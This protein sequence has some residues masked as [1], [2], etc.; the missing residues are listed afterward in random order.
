MYNKGL[1][2]YHGSLPQG[3]KESFMKYRMLKRGVL[4]AMVAACLC[5]AGCYV[6]P[7]EI[8]D[9]TQ[10]MTIGSNNLPFQTLPPQ[11]TVTPT[12]TPTARPQQGQ[13]NQQGQ[14][15]GNTIIQPQNT[16]NI[17]WDENWGSTATA[18]PGNVPNYN[19]QGGAITVVTQKPT[20]TPKPATPTPTSNSLK[21]GS[22]GAAVRELQQ[23]LKDLG[24]YT[25][26]VDGDF[27]TGTENA[28]RAF[29]KANG[30]TQDGKAGKNTLAKLY[31]NN[32]VPYSASQQGQQN[33]QNQQQNQNRVTP[34][35]RPT[36]TPNL[37]NARYLTVGYSGND[38][39]RLQQRLIDLGYLG[40][41]ANGDFGAA[42]KAAVVA[43]QGRM[44]LWDDGIAGP[45][46]QAKL[47]SNSA[48]KASS[49][50][51]Y[52]GESLKQ[53]MNGDGVRA[54][55]KQL[56]KLGYY[57]GTVDGDYGSG[58]VT[59]VMAFQQNNGLK[60]DG[61]AGNATLNK[62][63]A[64]D[65][66]KA[67]GTIGNNNSNGNVIHSSSGTNASGVGSSQIGQSGNNNGGMSGTGGIT[68]Q[69]SSTG[70]YTL[71]EGDKS[72]GVRKLQQALKN[73]GYYSG[74]VDG[75]YGSGTTSAVMAFQRMNNLTVDG[76]AGPATQRALYGTNTDLT[77]STLREGDEGP[78][79]L[80]L[81]YTLY[82]LGYYDGEMNS[83]YGATTR[84][85]VRAFQIA[86]HLTPVDGVAGNKT[87]Q[88]LYS[89]NA[90]PAQAEN[91]TYTTLRKGD[92]GDDVVQ[93]QDVLCQLGYLKEVTGEYDNATVAAVRTFQQ[94]NGL[95]V[96]GVAGATTQQKLYSNPVP[97]P[98]W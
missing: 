68:G 28:V 25:G 66:V 19:G 98:S 97:F 58:T 70:Y 75:T 30:L 6:P 63:Y 55:Q 83:V 64:D 46:T 59:A 90:V 96:D 62:L 18:T 67:N 49:M 81:Q 50:A 80:N 95:A 48:K 88:K 45:D 77:Y 32:A 69:V 85:A 61:I 65:V 94:Y 23:R 21:N 86:N 16:P 41:K 60:A 36:A 35:P 82:E 10:N 56:K 54:L 57:N 92:R 76:K 93:L 22:T 42:T 73:L 51:A 43:F 38:V 29:Q 27:G 84:D 33:Q 72:D 15:G 47:Y 12:P 89:S 26:T 20:N 91:N 5:L 7:D 17:N 74:K 8:S 9:N 31:S 3:R 40:G 39:K 14:Q 11:V 2:S 78:A 1:N 34:M 79:V 52:T 53:G 44:G 4:V 24:Y 87:L 13:E 71:Q 37:T